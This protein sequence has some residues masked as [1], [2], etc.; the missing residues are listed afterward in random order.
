M[1]GRFAAVLTLGFASFFVIGA[2]G[3]ASDSYFEYR[4][5]LATHD[6]PCVQERMNLER[7]DLDRPNCS[8]HRVS[9]TYGRQVMAM[10]LTRDRE[11]LD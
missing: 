2:A 1:Q 9:T 5:S 3:A 4:L 8:V 10:N 6:V 7:P 11:E